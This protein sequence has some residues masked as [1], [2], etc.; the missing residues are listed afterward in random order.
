MPPDLAL[1][2]TLVSSNYPYLD[3]VSW[4][5]RCSSHWSST[6]VWRIILWYIY[7]HGKFYNKQKT[8]IFLSDSF[9]LNFSSVT[10]NSYAFPYK[11][12][13]WKPQNNFITIK[14]VKWGASEIMPK[15]RM[16]TLKISWQSLANSKPGQGM[17]SLP[18]KCHDISWVNCAF[19]GHARK[20]AKLCRLCCCL[21]TGF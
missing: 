3:H 15:R 12:C 6:V 10:C 18:R 8:E 4:L 11:N 20:L 17:L 13:E 19:H 7:F 21:N 2:L 16:Q 5:Q 9:D 1:W 14:H